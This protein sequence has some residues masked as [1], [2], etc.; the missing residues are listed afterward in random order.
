MVERAHP[1]PA[2][3]HWSLRGAA[4]TLGERAILEP[5]TLDLPAGRVYGLIGPNGSGK[6]T[7]LKM[8]ARQLAPSGG[9]LRFDGRPLGAWAGR[10]F[11]REVAYMPQF[12]PAS[13]GMNVREL[14]SLGR[15]PWHGALGRFS[16]ED[17]ARVEAAIQRTGLAA[18]RERAV[19]SLSG[20]ERQR[21]W[22]ALMLAQGA[23]CLLLDEPTSALDIAH[24][25]E[26]LAI[27]RELGG[28]AT[29]GPGQQGA[30][31]VIVILHDINLA[32]R[33]CDALL[34]LRGGRLIAHGP[35]HEIMEPE[36]LRAIYG[37]DMGV[38]AHPVSGTPMSYVL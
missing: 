6:S 18:F 30:M 32:A 23:R 10:A 13:D 4:F 15:Y 11:A 36:R 35:C 25:M 16:A 34:A 31:T 17:A 33:T 26:V 7:L 3:A 37:L 22:L 38:M 2:G 20:G 21:A 19:D 9:E 5:L 8:M 14:V 29:G 12:M 27:L 28:E 24:Q 1:A